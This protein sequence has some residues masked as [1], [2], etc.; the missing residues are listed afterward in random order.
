MKEIFIADLAKFE[1]QSVTAFF[2]ATTKSLR[3]KKDGGKY[4]A[5]VFTDRT[6]S[7]E[8]RMW[9]NAAEASPEFEQGDVVKLKALVCRY[10]ERLQMK[11]ERIRAALD[12]E[13]D[14][15]DFLPETTKD[16]DALWAE[17]NS[18]VESFSDPHLKALL[19]AF[20][21]D[22]EIADGL[23]PGACGKGD[24]PRLA[25]WPARARRLTDGR[26]R[27]RGEALSRDPSRPVAHRRR[28]ARYRQA[29]RT[30]LEEELR[31]HHP[32]PVARAHHH[33][34]RHDR[35]EARIAA[36]FSA[37]PARARSS[38]WCSA[39]TGTTSTARPSCP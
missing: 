35:E 4:L 19:R 22:P 36:G 25:G 1:D 11:V 30:G 39:I 33:R 7:M 23:P 9:D 27:T 14:P 2:A 5:L 10:Q 16:V 8:A 13:Y 24:A 6:G 20:L 3:D 34:L 31:L 32:G 12:G 17:L 21:D 26:L 38:T 29:A 15:A 18:Y 37:A 28:A